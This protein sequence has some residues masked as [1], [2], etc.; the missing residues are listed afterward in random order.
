MSAETYKEVVMARTL[1]VTSGSLFDDA[2]PKHSDRAPS[3]PGLSRAWPRVPA[4]NRLGAER[5]K[6]TLCEYALIELPQ[7]EDSRPLDR[8]LLNL[9][10]LLFF[11]ALL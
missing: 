5:R 2:R 11:S 9:L 6:T 3:S 10:P 7:G 4:P 8:A 1:P